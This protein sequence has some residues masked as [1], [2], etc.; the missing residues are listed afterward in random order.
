MVSRSAPRGRQ[1]KQGKVSAAEKAGLVFPPRRFE[2]L[3]REVQGESRR[4]S[5]SAPVILAAIGEQV[6]AAI[7]ASA[8]GVIANARPRRSR[9]GANDVLEGVASDANLSRLFA[10]APMHVGQPL[11]QVGRTVQRAIKKSAR[12]GQA[13]AA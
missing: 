9:L 11:K 5:A 12:A 4:T 10:D 2:T 1:E 7:L 13:Q 6:S 8:S 3:L